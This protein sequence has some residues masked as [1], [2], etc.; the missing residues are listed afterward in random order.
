MRNYRIDHEGGVQEALFSWCDIQRGKYPE[1]RLLYHVPNGG[2]RD[3]RTAQALKRQGVKAGVPDL[4]LPVARGGWHGLYI[5]LKVGKNKPTE[6]QRE[7]LKNL[8]QQDYATAVCYGW[9]EAA[10]VLTSYLDH[11][12]LLAT[13]ATA[14]ALA[15]MPTLQPAT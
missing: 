6:H 1:L 14:A 7:W 13:A 4:C 3:A 15:D 10:D 8:R 5:E 12:T 11:S 9:E 2:K